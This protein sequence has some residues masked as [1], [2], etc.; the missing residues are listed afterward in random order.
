MSQEKRLH[1]RKLINAKVMLIHSEIG[2]YH[3]YTHDISDG[4]VFVLLQKMPGLPVGAQLD[5]RLLNSGQPDYLFKMEI[6][7]TEKFGLGLKFLGFEKK[8]KFHSMDILRNEW[9]KHGS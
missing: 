3:T 5:M 1:R 8:G 4:G 6:A 2:E 7:R 9:K